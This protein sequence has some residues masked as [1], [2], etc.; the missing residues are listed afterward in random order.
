MTR[1]AHTVETTRAIPYGVQRSRARVIAACPVSAAG[2]IVSALSSMCDAPPEATDSSGLH[3]DARFVA[4]ESDYSALATCA[5]ASQAGLRTFTVT[6]GDGLAYMHQMLRWCAAARLPVVLA[7]VNR[8]PGGDWNVLVDQNDSL[9]QRDTGWIQFHCE[10]AQEALDTIIQ[11]FRVAEQ[12][13]LPAMICLDPPEPSEP[14]FIAVPDQRLVDAFLPPFKAPFVLDTDRPATFGSRPG[15]NTYMELR[16][17]MER[18]MA[19]AR[20]AAMDAN[21][22]YAGLVAR[23]Y[24]IVETY[25]RDESRASAE[26]D[27]ALVTSGA[28]STTARQVV[29]ERWHRGDR[30]RLVKI[31]LFRPFP[32]DAVRAAIAG[33]RKVAVFDRSISFGHGGIMAAEVRAAAHFNEVNTAS[34][35]I[36]SF[37]GG[38]GGRTV[39]PEAL[40]AAIDH[41]LDRHEPQ[42][43][44]LWVD[45]EER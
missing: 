1:L 19:Q 14:E 32:F 17:G 3:T 38:L 4:A 42:R 8:S 43:D 36:F 45:L 30:V 11:A 25:P 28:V 44:V 12:V 35:P 15:P 27:V 23:R 18:A 5:G 22:E 26:V 29:D 31:R 33:A 10:N 39:T 20:Q 21:E 40:H 7:N 16:A 9:C 41:S 37:V 6:A 2:D 24:S 34:A 13:L